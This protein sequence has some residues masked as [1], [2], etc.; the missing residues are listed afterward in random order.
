VGCPRLG[1]AEFLERLEGLPNFRIFLRDDLVA[2]WPGVLKPEERDE[3]L[4]A[5]QPCRL[6]LDG[7][8]EFADDPDAPTKD[9]FPG[10][11]RSLIPAGSAL[12]PP[13][14][15]LDHSPVRYSRALARGLPDPR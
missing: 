13:Q 3:L 14:P 12:A 11:L 6:L 10:M 15:I 7:S 9:G 8:I 5:G 1:N 4:H 2:A